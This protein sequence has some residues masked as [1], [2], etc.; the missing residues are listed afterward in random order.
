MLHTWLPA[1]LRSAGLSV[2][3]TTGWTNRS[4][5]DLPDSPVVVWHHDASPEGDS[6]GALDWMI[7]NWDNA[8]AQIWINRYGIVYLVGCGIAW[9]A[10]PV[11]EGMPGNAQSVGIETDH[12]TGEDWPAELLA[13]LRTVTVVILR[14]SQIAADAGLYFHRQIARPYGRKSDPDGLVLQDEIRAVAQIMAGPTP[15][16]K[17]TAPPTPEEPTVTEDQMRRLLD[18]IGAIGVTNAS[19][20]AGTREAVSNLRKFSNEVPDRVKNAVLVALREGGK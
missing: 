17:P 12:T 9:H 2:I 11:L 16:P 4:H 14:C 10:G 7:S 8:S 19:L 3:E 20:E 13:A 6:P 15:G 5:G 1:A 18:A